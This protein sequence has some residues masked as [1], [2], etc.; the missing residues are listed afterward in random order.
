MKLTRLIVFLFAAIVAVSITTNAQ[1]INSENLKQVRVDDISDAEIKAYYQKATNSGLTETQLYRMATERGMPE[2]E[3]NKLKLRIASLNT[4][5][6]PQKETTIQDDT[7]P[8]SVERKVNDDAMKVPMQKNNRDTTIFGTELFKESS[9]VFEPNL[10]IPSPINYI[11]GPDDQLLVDVFGYSEQTY[12]LTVNSEGNVY[13]PNVGPIKVNSISIEEAGDKIR[14]KLAATIYKAI[15]TG[16]TKVEV[17]LGKIRSIRV[18]VIGQATKPGTYTVSSLTTLF[19]MLYLCGGPSDMGSFRNIELIRDNKAIRKIDLYS[20]LLMGDRKDNLLLQEQDVIRIPYYSTRVKMDGAL[21]RPGKFELQPTE[22]FD[23]LLTYSGGFSDSAYRSSVQV[24]RISDAGLILSDVNAQNFGSFMPRTGDAFMV[25]KGTNRFTNRVTIKGAV[26]RP[27][28]FELKPGMTLQQ[29]IENAGGL[30]PD[31]YTDRGFIQ[32]QND[33]L[34]FSSKSFVV[35]DVVNG[36]EAVPLKK[37]DVIS[38]SSILELKDA[39]TVN[40]E[41]AVR[42]PGTFS[43]SDSFTLKDLILKGGGF[44]ETAN[45]KAVEIS[46]RIKNPDIMKGNFRQTDILTVDLSK[47]LSSVGSETL[48]MPYDIVNVRSE[49]GYN[50]P[51]MVYVEGQ[52]MNTGRYVLEASGERVSNLLK[53]AG[54]FKGSADS[55]YITIRRFINSGLSVEERQDIVERMLNI[56]KDSLESNPRLRSNFLKNVELLGVNVAKV[57]SNPGGNEDLILESGDLITVARASNLVRVN[58]EVFHPTLLPF[59]THS[60]A[61]YYIRRSGNFT[62]NARRSGVFVIYPDGRAKSVKRF[63]FIKSYPSVTPRSEVYVPTKEKDNKHGFGPGE[64]IAVSSIIASLA[65]L[66]VAVVR[67]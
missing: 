22:N 60:S 2:T 18:T 67:K 6:R 33:D 48:L 20:F 55:T 43:Y 49:S 7:E 62:N 35:R 63:L 47:G 31:A 42:T 26:L 59:E 51:R 37:E 19:N 64:W 29:L 34:T 36:T 15:R 3:I 44:S 41:G 30:R 10:R 61:R 27:G 40:I 52:V 65:T 39:L 5:N 56:D 11:L 38:V 50:T 28:D 17:S 24:T 66:I 53:R 13:I 16:Q 58:G 9:M 25:S 8:K 14:N 46:R 32:R 21:K 45:P 4:A 54:G 57:N 23:Q 1:S 12:N